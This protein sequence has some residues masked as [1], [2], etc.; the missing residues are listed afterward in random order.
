[1]SSIQKTAFIIAAVYGM[2]AVI[3]AALGS[4]LFQI[5]KTTTNYL[6]FNNAVIYQLL[7]SVLVLWLSTLKKP[8]FWIRSAIISMLIGVTLFCFGLYLFAIYGKTN[9]SFITPIGGS[10]IIL[11]WLNLTISGFKKHL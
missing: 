4:H 11:G 5:D 6:I 3:F 1:V 2:T 7:H 8:N 9:F 10:L